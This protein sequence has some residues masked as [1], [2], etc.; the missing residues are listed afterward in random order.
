MKDI[1]EKPLFHYVSLISSSW[2]CT[3]TVC[4]FYPVIYSDSCLQAVGRFCKGISC[5]YHLSMTPQQ[6]E[7]RLDFSVAERGK[8]RQVPAACEHL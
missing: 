8:D 2:A 1:M 7:R 3:P 5:V 6:A 4:T